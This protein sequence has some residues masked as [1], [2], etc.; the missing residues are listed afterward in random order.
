MK[1]YLKYIIPVIILI[2]LGLLIFFITRDKV[3]EK[4]FSDEYTSVPKDNLF[5]YRDKDEIIK[6]LKNGTGVVY[7]GFPE[8]PWCQAYA[9][10]LDEVGKEEGLEK[11]YYYNILEDRKNNTKEYQEMVKLLKKHLDFDEEGNERIFVP[12]VAFVVK[13]LIVASDNETSLI[14]GETTPEEYWTDSK[15]QEL[16]E[17]LR[18]YINQV[19]NEKCEEC[20]V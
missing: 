11:I 7:L 9:P 4:N 15:K 14:S 12:E 18:V 6:I 16:K 10:I 19:L 8:C 20:S 17:K 2:V 1:K 5:V 13:G 3:E